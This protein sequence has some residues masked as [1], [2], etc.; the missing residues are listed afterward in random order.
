MEAKCPTT[1]EIARNCDWQRRIGQV[2]DFPNTGLIECQECHLVTHEQDLRHQVNYG[3]GSMHNWASGY[4]DSLPLVNS[5]VLRRTIALDEVAKAV[6]I[7]SI[8]DF[9]CGPGLMLQALQSK[10]DVTGIEPEDIA[11]A[12]AKKLGH[13]VFESFDTAKS[14]NIKV[15]LVTM[16]HVVEHFYEPALEIK[17]ILEL[18][19]PGGI[20][21]IETPNSLDAL[22]SKYE[23]IQFSNFTFWS[24]HPMLHSQVSLERMIKFCGYEIIESTGVQRYDINNHLHW[25]SHGLPGGHEKWRD[26]ASEKLKSEYAQLLV[27]KHIS[28]TLWLIARKP[29]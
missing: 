10:Y 28:D 27:E 23:S 5:D 16:F 13:N 25:L 6:S 26:F 21:V 11:R 8:L 14:S 9:G 12:T 20:L 19:R 1:G 7:G 2:R 17:R 15:D 29:Q 24:H 3:S 4:G 18:L 22:L